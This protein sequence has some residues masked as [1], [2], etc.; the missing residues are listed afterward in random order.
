[1]GVPFGN[2]SYNWFNKPF[3]DPKQTHIIETI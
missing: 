1:L 2:Y 3:D